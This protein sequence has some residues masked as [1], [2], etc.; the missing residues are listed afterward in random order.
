M[1]SYFEPVEGHN[2][3]SLQDFFGN[4]L[5]ITSKALTDPVT[6]GNATVGVEFYTTAT[7]LEIIAKANGNKVFVYVDGKPISSGATWTLASD[8]LLN[9]LPLTFAD[10][11]MKRVTVFCVLT[12]FGGINTNQ[13]ATVFKGTH[14]RIKCVVMGDS[15]TEGTGASNYMKSYVKTLGRIL[16][17][18]ITHVGL[19]GTGY[20]NP[21][22]SVKFRSRVQNDVIDSGADVVIVAGGLNDSS[23]YTASAIQTEAGLLFAAIRAGLPNARLIV[24]A[25][26]WSHGVETYTVGLLDTRDAIKTAALATN[27]LWVDLLEIP[28]RA[29]QAVSTTLSNAVAA[30]ATS[31]V[32]PVLL[33]L[34]STIEIGTGAA[35]QRRV[36]GAV[37]GS[38]G[39]WTYTGLA[40]LA[41]ASA[42]TVVNLVGASLWTGTGRVG[43]TTGVGNS[44]VLTSSDGI[45]QADP[46]HQALAY[47]IANQTVA[48][49]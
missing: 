42:G 40:S 21:G 11:S 24:V 14:N 16:D 12:G 8:G 26:F 38:T 22:A 6:N 47:G 1:P 45:H 2:F 35:R 18:D 29:G 49:W 4:A 15:F 41:A 20:L 44:D 13:S 43:A 10:A 7:N 3:N 17:W 30:S 32:L 25:P 33:P 5:Y 37:S 31:I 27:A 19:G 34:G 48:G 28:L 36:L 39:A 46:G 23:G 9:Y